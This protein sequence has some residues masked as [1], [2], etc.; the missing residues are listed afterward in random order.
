MSSNKALVDKIENKMSEIDELF[1]SHKEFIEEALGSDDEPKR[2]YISGFSKVLHDFYMGLENIFELIAK[3]IDGTVPDGESSHRDLINQIANVNE[4]RIAVLSE[5]VI[6]D[7]EMYLGF[8]HKSRHTYS[9]KH[10]WALM[11]PLILNVRDVWRDVNEE[12]E[13]FIKTLK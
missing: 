3:E 11:R 10:E 4:N 5:D 1:E 2:I 7:L 12:L 6:S 8:R 13:A 9:Y